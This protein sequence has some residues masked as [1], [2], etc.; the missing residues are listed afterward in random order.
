MPEKKQEQY[1]KHVNNKNRKQIAKCNQNATEPDRS[2]PSQAT[3]YSILILQTD[4][5]AR[6]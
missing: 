3:S 6:K 2:M 4:F 1:K 5:C